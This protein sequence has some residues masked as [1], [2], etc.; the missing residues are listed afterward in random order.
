MT[1]TPGYNPAFS[2]NVPTD[3]Q[4]SLTEIVAAAYLPDAIVL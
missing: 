2:C 3:K 4:S 1:K